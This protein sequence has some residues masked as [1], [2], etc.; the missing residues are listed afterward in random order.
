MA[1]AKNWVLTDAA[2]RVWVESIEIGPADLG[3]AE[4]GWSIRKTTL[5]GGP[6]DG[7]DLIEVDNGALSFSLLPTRGMGI[8]KGSYKGLDVGWDSPVKGPVHPSLIDLQDRGGLGWLAGFDELVVRCGL[9]STG[10]PGTDVVPNNMGVSTEVAL[11][12]HGKIANIPAS[13]VEV[14][15][16]PGEP[17]QLV[18]LGEVR[19]AGL[20]CPQYKLLARASTEVGSNTLLIEDEVTNE[21]AIDAEMELLYHCNFGPPFLEAGA[22]LEV[23]AREVAPRDERAAENMDSYETYLGPTAGYVEQ[24]YWYDLLPDAA[25]RTL[26]MLRSATADKGLVLRFDCGQLPAFT[27]WKNTASMADGYVTGLEPA[28]D[29]PNA[30]DFERGKGRL[31][32]MGPGETRRTA[33]ALEIL[34]SAEAVC[35]VQDEIAALQQTVGRQVHPQPIGKYSAP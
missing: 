21:K 30:K 29:Y 19:E 14:Q 34:D 27:Q 16:I 1:E 24:V 31:M 10:A 25:G 2:A 23:A 5:R 11:T 33:L 9:D 20:F 12:L 15:V 3:L 32:K 26:A 28:T 35:A 4:E 17:T 13:R 6:G 7:V 22:R 18:V 8:W